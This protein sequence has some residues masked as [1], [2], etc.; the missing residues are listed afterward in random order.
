MTTTT[1]T[2]AVGVFTERRLADRA[3]EELHNAGFSNEQIGFIS[4][5]GYTGDKPELIIPAP[6]GYCEQAARLA[7]LA[8]ARWGAIEHPLDA[9]AALD[10]LLE[11]R[12]TTTTA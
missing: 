7:A 2:T 10:R 3:I 9:A 6:A 1:R 5:E 12:A 11:T 8:G 4:R